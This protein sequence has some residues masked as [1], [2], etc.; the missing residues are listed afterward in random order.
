MTDLEKVKMMEGMNWK[1]AQQYWKEQY[2]EPKSMTTL[3]GEL[4]LQYDSDGI[5]LVDVGFRHGP[6]QLGH[7]PWQIIATY[8]K[9][10][11]SDLGTDR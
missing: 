7:I 3:K 4:E 1:P 10:Y 2:E 5:W 8:I 11:L 9:E 6:V